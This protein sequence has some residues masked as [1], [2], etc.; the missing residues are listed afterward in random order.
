MAQ[1][2]REAGLQVSELW[3]TSVYPLVLPKSSMA[4]AH[5]FWPL[6]ITQLQKHS[7]PDSVD[8]LL[9]SVRPP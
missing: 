3:V 4:F 8:S 2:M 7:S 9:Y 6:S 1:T 5:V